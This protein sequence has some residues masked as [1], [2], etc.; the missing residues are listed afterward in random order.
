M[1]SNSPGK[2]EKRDRSRSRSRL[3]S[4][5]TFFESVWRQSPEKSAAEEPV[6]DRSQVELL[7]RELVDKRERLP[8]QETSRPVLRRV[9][10][11]VRSAAP[12]DGVTVRSWS[13]VAV[14]QPPWRL[15]RRSEPAIASATPTEAL[16][17]YE[18]W[19]ARRLTDEADRQ[20]AP[21][22][23]QAAVRKSSE[24]LDA[25]DEAPARRAS[26]QPQWYSEFRAHSIKETA[27]RLMTS[28]ASANNTYYDF[29]ITQIKG[30]SRWV[31]RALRHFLP[32]CRFE[33]KIV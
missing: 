23:K 14:E 16:S 10:S 32:G 30:D 8:R 7:E 20:V 17:K 9:V 6:F 2:G 33:G 31:C 4:R 13:D 25:R 29:H 22:R 28:A 26:H 18:E 15:A 19:R 12:S 11:P 27:E 1:A 24:A 3:S 21:W 5:V